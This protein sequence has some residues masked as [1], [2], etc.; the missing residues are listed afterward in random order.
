V[1]D[2][3]RYRARATQAYRYMQMR[4]L[5]ILSV[6][7]SSFGSLSWAGE[8]RCKEHEHFL[9][10]EERGFE[11]VNHS[12]LVD[13]E[14]LINELEEAMWFIEEVACTDVGFKVVASHVQYN[15]P[16]KKEFII[17]VVGKGKYEI[18]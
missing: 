14:T 5:L 16:T 12:V 17:K 10:L 18:K 6:L 11:H 9:L 13:G 1:C 4:K 7:I 3:S 8:Y 15:D 2:A